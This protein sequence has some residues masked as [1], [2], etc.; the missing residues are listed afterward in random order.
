[1]PWNQEKPL[2][3][4]GMSSV[5]KSY[6]ANR[7]AETGVRHRDCDAVIADHL[8]ELVPVEDGQSPVLAVG[9]WM[10]MPNAAG[11]Q[12]REAQYLAL[13]ERVTR[14]LLS[15]AK[16]SADVEV[17]DTTGSVVH[18]SDE[19][20]EEL[21]R[22]CHIVY[23]E[24]PQIHQ[25]RL[26]DRYLAAPKPIVWGPFFD[27][28]PDEPS[29]QALSRGYKNLLR[30]RGERYAALSHKTLDASLLEQQPPDP[31]QLISLL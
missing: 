2:C 14:E 18:L 9:A 28:N 21:R 17:L 5:G 8:G 24:A 30:W 31:A 1:M 20:L 6:W 12:K 26:L 22:S 13:E 19:L 25:Q 11:F 16:E 27:P 15:V 29:D 23:L 3:L 10:G 7:L 4:V